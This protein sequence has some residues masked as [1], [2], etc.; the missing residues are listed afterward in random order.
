MVKPDAVKHI[1]QILERIQ[2]ED[3]VINQ[4]KKVNVSRF[5]K[6]FRF[7]SFYFTMSIRSE[8]NFKATFNY[9]LL[10]TFLFS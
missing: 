8:S 7:Q 9:V 5:V 3:F 2:S 4:M 6:T 10:K 1:G